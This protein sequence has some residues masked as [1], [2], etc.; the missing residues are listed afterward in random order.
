MQRHVFRYNRIEQIKSL[1]W[2]FGSVLSPEIKYNLSEHEIQWFNKYN[3][4]L[5]NYMRSIGTEGGLDLT[6]DI[7]PPKSLYIEVGYVSSV[8]IVYMFYT[9]SITAMS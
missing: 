2:E 3:K 1:R 4:C 8:L 6:Q 5:A 7:K 9:A